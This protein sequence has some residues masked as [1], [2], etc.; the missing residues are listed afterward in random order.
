MEFYKTYMKPGKNI[1]GSIVYGV[2]ASVRISVMNYAKCDVRRKSY[3]C[4]LDYSIKSL[5]GNA[6]WFS[7]DFIIARETIMY[8][9]RDH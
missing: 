4:P 6:I 9:V 8:S 7:D 3:I 2:R 1:A 5:Y